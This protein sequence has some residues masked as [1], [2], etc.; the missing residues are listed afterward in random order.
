[1]F[2]AEHCDQED[3]RTWIGAGGDQFWPIWTAFYLL[4]SPRWYTIKPSGLGSRTPTV[5]HGAWW[6]MPPLVRYPTSIYIYYHVSKRDTCKALATNTLST[7]GD[8]NLI[9]AGILLQFLVSVSKK[10]HFWISS[11]IKVFFLFEYTIRVC[12]QTGVVSKTLNENLACPNGEGYTVYGNF[13]FGNI[14]F[15]NVCCVTHCTHKTL[16]AAPRTR[17]ILIILLILNIL[18]LTWISRKK[19]KSIQS[20]M[21][22]LSPSSPTYQRPMTFHSKT[23]LPASQPGHYLRY[24]TEPT[25]ARWGWSR[26]QCEHI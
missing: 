24:H 6:G 5:V 15:C 22:T 17:S 9:A 12:L 19:E 13:P 7:N 4:H 18:I 21:K 20:Q 25:K 11:I 14:V 2:D 8:R 3:E 23:I 1:M 16:G 10:N 26:A